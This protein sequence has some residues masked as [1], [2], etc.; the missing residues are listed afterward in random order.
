MPSQTA[1]GNTFPP[2]GITPVFNEITAL[3]TLAS[4]RPKPMTSFEDLAGP[5]ERLLMQNVVDDTGVVQPTVFVRSASFAEPSTGLS[6]QVL[7][8]AACS[9]VSKS[10]LLGGEVAVHVRNIANAPGMAP[11]ELPPGAQGLLDLPLAGGRAVTPR[12]FSIGKIQASPR[13]ATSPPR[14]RSRCITA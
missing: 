5:K 8:L 13:T 9:G 7:S 3:I 2:G 11:I 6:T 4:Q 1:S 14:S 12:Q 10:Q